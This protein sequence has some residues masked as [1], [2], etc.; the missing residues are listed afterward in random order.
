MVLHITHAHNFRR[1]DSRTS[2]FF[3]VTQFLFYFLIFSYF[4]QDFVQGQVNSIFFVLIRM[5]VFVCNNDYMHVY[6]HLELVSR[7][8]IFQNQNC[9]CLWYRIAIA[10]ILLGVHRYCRLIA[11]FYSSPS[12]TL[13]FSLFLSH[14]PLTNHIFRIFVFINKIEQFVEPEIKRIR[15][16]FCFFL[17]LTKWHIHTYI[18]TFTESCFCKFYTTKNWF[19]FGYRG[20][21]LL[22]CFLWLLGFTNYFRI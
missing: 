15:S 20:L 9:Y 19:I 10:Y 1:F 13:Y 17:V 18:Y 14:S 3:E 7:L 8:I 6:V 5:H 22:H 16:W 4:F 11:R 21:H 12:G 2:N